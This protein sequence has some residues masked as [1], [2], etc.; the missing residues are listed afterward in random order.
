MCLGFVKTSL[1]IFHLNI[2]PPESH[3]EISINKY[4]WITNDYKIMFNGYLFVFFKGLVGELKWFFKFI[5]IR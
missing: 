1:L 4:E 2:D 3:Y 5:L